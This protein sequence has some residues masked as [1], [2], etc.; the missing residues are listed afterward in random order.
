MNE[1]TVGA[2]D[3][4]SAIAEEYETMMD[5]VMSDELPGSRTLQYVQWKRE[6]QQEDDPFPAL[7][8]EVA[9]QEP[10]DVKDPA[11]IATQETTPASQKSKKPEAKKQRRELPTLPT[12]A[13][14][15]KFMAWLDEAN[16]VIV[17]DRTASPELNGDKDSVDGV[18]VGVG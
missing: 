17:D 10:G 2:D 13:Q 18:G 3:V 8:E 14:K 15:E 5:I 1:E 12:S 9:T 16:D 4:I 11:N 6:V 7:D